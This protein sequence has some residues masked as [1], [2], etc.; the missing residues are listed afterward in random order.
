[1]KETKT[2]YL[3]YYDNGVDC[4]LLFEFETALEAV[5]AGEKEVKGWGD[6]SYVVYEA[7][8]IGRGKGTW[9]DKIVSLHVW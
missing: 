7:V 6:C 9:G 4:S 8:E 2:V 1:M 3:M 5:E